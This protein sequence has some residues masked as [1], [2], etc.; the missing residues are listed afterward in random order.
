MLAERYAAGVRDASHGLVDFQLVDRLDVDGFPVKADGCPYTPAA[1][2][3]HWQRRG[4]C[5]TR[6]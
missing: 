2:W 3:S 6:R 4:G 1:Y 5:Q